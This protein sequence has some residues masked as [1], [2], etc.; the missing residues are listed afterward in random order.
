MIVKHDA[1]KPTSF[2][3]KW[4]ISTDLICVVISVDKYNFNLANTQ[5]IQIVIY[6]LLR[7][8]SAEQHQ[9]HFFKRFNKKNPKF[10]DLNIVPTAFHTHS[11]FRLI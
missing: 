7:I 6:I 11:Q 4:R 3:R 2:Y 5:H 9:K 8:P 10:K 1:K